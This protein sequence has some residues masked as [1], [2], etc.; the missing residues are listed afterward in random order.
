MAYFDRWDKIQGAVTEEDIL[1]EDYEVEYTYSM[2][3]GEVNVKGIANGKEFDV[4]G[5][6]LTRNHNGAKL[7]YESND[8]K[9]NY[10]ILYS[11]I[12]LAQFTEFEMP[13][14]EPR[15][16]VTSWNHTPYLFFADFSEKNSKYKNAIVLYLNPNE[17]DDV[18]AIEIF[19]EDN[20]TSEYQKN[21]TV[22]YNADIADKHLLWFSYWYQ[23]HM[24]IK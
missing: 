8:T 7:I 16:E 13:K 12:E 18:L 19:I 17:T 9:G 15:P 24:E 4:T 6:I 20:F 5:T 22:N 1:K 10:K 3:N 21:N 14:D 2:K 11:A 23:S